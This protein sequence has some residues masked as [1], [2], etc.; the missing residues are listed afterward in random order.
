MGYKGWE[1]YGMK[2]GNGTT[3]QLQ[4]VGTLRG[5][6]W[7]NATVTWVTKR[8][9]AMGSSLEHRHCYNGLQRVGTLRDI[10]TFRRALDYLP[11]ATLS[12]DHVDRPHRPVI[13]SKV[14]GTADVL[15]SR[16][17]RQLAFPR[18][19]SYKLRPNRKGVY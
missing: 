18:G 17:V 8:G 16:S 12:Q 13:R 5:A 14:Y 7:N 4:W 1:R 3:P 10:F 9:N 2:F 6:A 19:N 15:N 11:P